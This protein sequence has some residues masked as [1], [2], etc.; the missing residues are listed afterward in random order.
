VHQQSINLESK[1]KEMGEQVAKE[2]QATQFMTVQDS[3]FAIRA[4]QALMDT[5]II[6]RNTYIYG[7]FLPKNVVQS[8]FENLQGLLEQSIEKLSFLLEEKGPKDKNKIVAATNY[9][10]ERRDKFTEAIMD[11]DMTTTGKIN[12][13]KASWESSKDLAKDPL[14]YNGWIYGS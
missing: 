7:Y 10:A 4:I 13:A 9:V 8:L 5:R 6:L 1:L 3:Q 2:C 12:Q 11:S 14:L